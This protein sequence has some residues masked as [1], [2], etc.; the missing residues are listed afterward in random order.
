MSFSLKFA[1]KFQR[2]LLATKRRFFKKLHVLM[3]MFAIMQ[4]LVYYIRMIFADNRW[5]ELYGYKLK[6]KITKT[7]AAF[8]TKYWIN[9]VI[10]FFIYILGSFMSSHFDYIH[11]FK[12]WNR[13]FTFVSVKLYR[14]LLIQTS[15]F[16]AILKKRECWIT[17]NNIC[18]ITGQ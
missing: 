10:L 1:K 13:P 4:C 3:F 18:V 17:S 14:V 7:K 6:T 16:V 11:F 2:Y 9:L 12:R 5:K 8:R 15:I